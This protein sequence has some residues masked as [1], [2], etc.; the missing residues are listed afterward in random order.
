MDPCKQT[1]DSNAEENSVSSPSTE[2]VS[3]HPDFIS[4]YTQISNLIDI[5]QHTDIES[6]DEFSD[7]DDQNLKPKD[8][9]NSLPQLSSQ[10]VE[11]SKE[12]F[13][14]YDDETDSNS[15][16]LQ[17]NSPGNHSVSSEQSDAKKLLFIQNKLL[18]NIEDNA[19]KLSTNVN[20]IM[21]FVVNS[22]ANMTSTTLKSIQGLESCLN[23][24]SDIVDINIKMFSGTILGIGIWL[25]VDPK[26]YE[27]S[28]HLETY[29]VI[30]AAYIMIIIGGFTMCLTFFG[31]FT[32][33]LQN[34]YMIITYLV[35]LLICFGMQV[36]IVTL[37]I[38]KGYGTR[39]YIFAYK[40]FLR[41]LQQYNYEQESRKFVDFFQIKLRCCGVES[42]NDYPRYGMAIPVSCYMAGHT[43]LNEKGCALALRQ[44]MELR[45]AVVGF[46]SFFDAIVHLIIIVLLFM[47]LC[48]KKY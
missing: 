28:R 3:V 2:E 21:K 18:K 10:I 19:I 38:N 17:C 44:F 48:V 9:G 16:I 4:S 46:L 32:T 33:V 27:P 45:T 29:N 24:T 12:R 35:F 40:E 31:I 34:V 14:T 23:E 37:A 7:I 47:L 42:F 13:N 11:W 15:P 22:S 20:E 26:S 36:A 25:I 6:S 39:L 1:I 30:H 43:Y 8:D 41:E 5:S